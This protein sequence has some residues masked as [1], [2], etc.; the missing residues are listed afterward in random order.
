MALHMGTSKTDLWVIC[1]KAMLHGEGNGLN[2]TYESNSQFREEL[3]RVGN[4]FF[5]F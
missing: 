2:G 4:T 5:L 1:Q 3:E